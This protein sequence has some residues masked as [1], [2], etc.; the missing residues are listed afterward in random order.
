MSAWTE[1]HQDEADVLM[2]M[3][4]RVWSLAGTPRFVDWFIE[5]DAWTTLA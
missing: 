5:P 2:E 1:G 3:F 4:D